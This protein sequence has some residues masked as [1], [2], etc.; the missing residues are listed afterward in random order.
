MIKGAIFDIDGVILDS[1]EMWNDLGKRYLSSM[2][3]EAEKGLNDILFSMSMEE[4][5]RYLSE[6]YHVE[7]SSV[8]IV[9]D[10][11]KTIE[12]GRPVLVGTINIDASIAISIVVIVKILD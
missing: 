6:H 3:I 5:A 9:E 10:I 7:K 11:K 4:G 8:E 2:G 12:T 1:M